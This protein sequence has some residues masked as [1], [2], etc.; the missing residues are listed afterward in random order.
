MCEIVSECP[1][2][3]IILKSDLSRKH[4][5]LGV[6]KKQNL[7][8]VLKSFIIYINTFFPNKNECIFSRTYLMF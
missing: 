2:I 7:R 6:K 3:C 8:Y 4:F 1:L 5:E